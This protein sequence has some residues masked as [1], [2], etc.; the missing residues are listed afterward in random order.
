MNE[1]AVLCNHVVVS[2]WLR[3]GQGEACASPRA[4]LTSSRLT[5]SPT[6]PPIPNGSALSHLH[7]ILSPSRDPDLVCTPHA[8]PI[9]L[10]LHTPQKSQVF[11]L[12]LQLKGRPARFLDSPD[13]MT[14]WRPRPPTWLQGDSATMGGAW[15]WGVSFQCSLYSLSCHPPPRHP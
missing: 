1:S 7:G 6:G 5:S 8:F 13:P 3:Q 15:L 12:S 10:Q 9:L 14:G 2:V 11:P 4:A